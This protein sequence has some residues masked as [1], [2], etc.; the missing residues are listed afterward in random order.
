MDIDE[1]AEFH[2]QEMFLGW[3]AIGPDMANDLAYMCEDPYREVP[4]GQAYWD[5]RTP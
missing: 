1:L 5:A 3:V 2:V 4:S